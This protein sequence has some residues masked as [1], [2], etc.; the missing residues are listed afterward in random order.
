MQQEFLSSEQRGHPSGKRRRQTL[1]VVFH[2]LTYPCFP[3]SCR[4]DITIHYALVTPGGRSQALQKAGRRGSDQSALYVR[5]FGP[6]KEIAL[7]G[8][9]TFGRKSAYP[10]GQLIGVAP[11][12]RWPCP[13]LHPTVMAEGIFSTTPWG[14]TETS[15]VSGSF[16][17]FRQ[18]GLHQLEITAW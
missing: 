18:I 3:G 9:I 4:S 6:P 5:D 7:L 8:I 10:V 17:A 12:R 1:V 11:P 16:H 2:S 15:G 13:G 14:R